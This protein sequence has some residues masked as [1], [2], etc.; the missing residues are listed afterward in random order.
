GTSQ[1]RLRKVTAD[2]EARA[3]QLLADGKILPLPPLP[4]QQPQGISPEDLAFVETNANQLQ[5]IPWGDQVA[6]PKGQERA[7]FESAMADVEASSG[8]W[9]KLGGPVKVF[10][11]LPRPLCHVGAA[12][13]MYRLSYLRGRL[14]APVGLRQGLRFALRAQIHTP[15]QPDALVVQLKLLSASRAAYWQELATKTLDM[16]R[17]VAPDHPRLPKAEMTYHEVRGEYDEALVCADRVIALANTPERK[18]LAL[19]GKATLLMSL[20]RYDET[21][22][23]FREAATLKPGDP[24][25]WHNL[26]IA[27][28]ELGR[29]QEALDCN[30]RALSI[31]DFGVARNQREILVRKLAEQ[32][33]NAQ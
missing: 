19:G 15:Q 12:E 25:I 4:Q 10:A 22:P 7:A 5:E 1:G 28:T 31:M 29:Y 27:L 32:Q 9:S 16:L 14:Y 33:G 24:W 2:S 30:E 11:G 8:D 3:K 17:Q 23:L 18:G 13:V 20:K 21:I 26:S 6:C